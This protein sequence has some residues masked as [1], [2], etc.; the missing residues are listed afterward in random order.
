MPAIG[1]MRYVGGSLRR[2]LV[3]GVVLVHALLMS[4]F[5]TDL[6]SR[7]RTELDKNRTDR[8]MG[9]AQMLAATGQPWVLSQDL[10]GL[11]D[12][13]GSAGAMPGLRYALFLS[14][15]GR[16]L[17]HTDPHQRGLTVADPAGRALLSGPPKLRTLA[18]TPTSVD[19]AAPVMING[20]LIGWSWVSLTRADDRAAVAIAI[21]KGL[22]YVLLA[23]IG[24]ALIAFLVAADIAKGLR[25]LAAV[26]NRFRAGDRSVRVTDTRLDEVGEL[27]RGV[28]AML[29]AVEAF[30]R[31]LRTASRMAKLGA[32]RCDLRTGTQV[33]TEEVL[34]MWGLDP[35]GPSPTAREFLAMLSP[36]DREMVNKVLDPS[37][38][39]EAFAYQFTV[40]RPD[41]REFICWTEGRVQYDESGKPVSLIGVS[42]DVTERESAAA[43][44]RQ[45]QKMEAVGQLT[46]GLAHDFNNL[47]AI[48]IGNLDLVD[49][50]LD[51]SGEAHAFNATALEAALKGAQLTQQ[52]LAFSR[53]Q[54]LS[55]RTIAP[56]D[57]L[58]QMSAIW[59]RTLGGGVVVR[60]QTTPELW[61][62]RADPSQLEAALLN[63]VINARDAM[64]GRGVLTIETH[65]VRLGPDYAGDNP[66]VAPGDY[67]MISVS[68]TGCGMTPEVLA[69]VFEPFFTTKGVGKGS[70]LGLSMIY[71]FAKQSGGHV[72]IYSEPGHGA[73]VRLFLP[74]AAEGV[75][76]AAQETTIP[77]RSAG[78]VVL[79]VEDNEQVRHVALRQLADLGYH[80][81]EADNGEAALAVVERDPRV[82]LLFT[83][84]VMP[85]GMTGMELVAA[86]RARR[87]NLKVLYTTGFTEAAAA[88]GGKFTGADVLLSKPYRRSELARKL[89]EVLEA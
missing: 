48:V 55:P 87:P 17:A 6:I 58:G 60:L 72:K 30:E 67:A 13:V 10:A 9:V 2:Q 57:L 84:V 49:A 77:P 70:G 12:I 22:L 19:V 18:S 76:A 28:N 68:D 51:P 86:A 29:E 21:W 8:A 43:Q 44:L 31:S 82:D 78:E 80:V 66:E 71:G 63:L 74:R 11:D 24:G 37:D 16:V 47:L 61:P 89:R 34:E 52:L 3:L 4:V 50:E 15:E 25:E 33:W 81:I 7:E 73:T 41:G 32:W 27:G 56:N 88:N 65:N 62:A 40:A 46:G 53:R 45:A 69:K 79:L 42:Q 1:L 36:A 38:P 54:P 26:S 64:D 5:L 35:H 59:T 39:K 23:V 83:D 75:R 85:G 14:P 20:R